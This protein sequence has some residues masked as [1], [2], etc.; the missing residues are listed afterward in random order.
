MLG[1]LLLNLASYD[2]ASAQQQGFGQTLGSPQDRQMFGNGASSGAGGGSL[3]PSTPGLGITN[4]I[5]LINRIR[6]STAL[7]DATPPASAV[8]QALK[9]LESQSAGPA[10]VGRPVAGAAAPVAGAAAPVAGA[11]APGMP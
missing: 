2:P 5:D 1:S 7:D 9:A 4:P 10:G 8:D 6:R 3:G 11:A